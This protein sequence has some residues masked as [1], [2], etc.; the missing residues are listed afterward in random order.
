[1]TL[2]HWNASMCGCG[3]LRMTWNY[4][5]T[6]AS[7]R[8]NAIT[9]GWKY[10]NEIFR[11]KSRTQTN[12]QCPTKAKVPGVFWKRKLSQCFYC[13]NFLL[14][15]VPFIRHPPPIHPKEAATLMHS[16]RWRCV[17]RESL[18]IGKNSDDE[19]GNPLIKVLFCFARSRVCVCVCLYARLYY[20]FY[21]LW[22]R[23]ILSEN[24]IYAFMI[25]RGA[26]ENL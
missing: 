17:G 21:A 20:T 26:R 7:R 3:A 16:E 4:L 5:A 23:Q 12:L 15:S 13:H 18:K 19:K 9:C 1:M 14:V 11:T 22:K 24:N 6:W 10:R 2:S 8:L 25:R